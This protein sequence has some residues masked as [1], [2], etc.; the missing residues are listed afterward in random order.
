MD[1]NNFA[2][3]DN[4]SSGDN[5]FLGISINFSG[6][7]PE[8]DTLRYFADLNSSDNGHYILMN[9]WVP[10]GDFELSF[11]FST[12]VTTG[13]PAVVGG[14]SNSETSIVVNFSTGNIQFF[15]FAGN[16]LQSVITGVGFNDGRLHSALCKVT[17]S[18][19]E[20]FVDGVSQ[21]V[22][23]WSLN[24]DEEISY[25]ARR[26]SGNY[27]EGI[28]ADA[29]FDDLS[30]AGNTFTF[31]LGEFDN[32][33]ELA[34]ESGNSVTYVGIINRHQ[35]TLVGGEKW[36]GENI[37]TNGGFD[38]D[39]SGW[40]V[41]TGGQTVEWVGG[42]LHIV[43][44]GT[45]AG[46]Q[47]TPFTAGEIYS[48]SGDYEAVSG[49]LKVQIGSVSHDLSTTEQFSVT[50][51]ATNSDLFLFRS[52]GAAEGYFDNLSANRNLIIT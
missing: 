1:L 28:I 40:N 4:V 27:F 17:G 38:S 32:D 30:G 8:L 51:T 33:V 5:N 47:Q 46:V 15:A 2:G 25:I 22:A 36:I 42:R 18:N 13:S 10:L 7:I 31:S 48:V 9:P 20:L 6:V 41:I 21:G 23:T 44:D 26:G 29:K 50:E 39:L 24:G 3:E 35:Y 19:A 11:K 14:T 45:G 37:L 16:S 34:D 12:S 52:S 49:S 43:T